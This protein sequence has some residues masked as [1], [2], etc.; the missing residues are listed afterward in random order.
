VN[1]YAS[2]IGMESCEMRPEI[3]VSPIGTS[4]LVYCKC[5]AG[6]TGSDGDPC[7]A[8]EAGKYKEAS[9]HAA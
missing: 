8:C 2:E 7:T 5:D 4:V 3:S 1:T 9:G 6:Y